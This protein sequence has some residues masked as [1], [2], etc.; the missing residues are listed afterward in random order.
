[1]ARVHTADGRAQDYTPKQIIDALN[2]NQWFDYAPGE[3][4]KINMVKPGGEVVSV[5]FTPE[6]MRETLTK[7]WRLEEPQE[8]YQGWMQQEY[9]SGTGELSAALLGFARGAT[10]GLSD[11]IAKE[12][13]SPEELNAWSTANPTISVGSEITGAIAPILLSGGAGAAKTGGQFLPKMSGSLAKKAMGYMPTAK[14]AK[15]TAKL[16]NYLM[17]GAFKGLATGKRAPT[18]VLGQALAR[19]TAYG[20]EGAVYGT[21]FGL[22]EAILQGDPILSEKTLAHMGWGSL[23][24]FGAGAVPGTI[25][26]LVRGEKRVIPGTER[27]A[28]PFNAADVEGSSIARMLESQVGKKQAKT[29]ISEAGSWDE[30]ARHMDEFTEMMGIGE[31]LGEQLPRIRHAGPGATEGRLIFSVPSKNAHIPTS[32]PHK[33]IYDSLPTEALKQRYLDLQRLHELIEID[34]QLLK[35]AGTKENLAKFYEGAK[36]ARG[37]EDGIARARELDALAKKYLPNKGQHVPGPLA[38]EIPQVIDSPEVLSEWLARGPSRE[39]MILFLKRSENILEAVRVS[40]LDQAEKL[41]RAGRLENQISVIRRRLGLEERPLRTPRMRKK[42]IKPGWTELENDEFLLL[43]SLARKGKSYAAVFNKVDGRFIELAGK[44]PKYY[45]KWLKA[46][47]SRLETEGALASKFEGT[48][49]RLTPERVSAEELETLL[50]RI[51]ARSTNRA[52]RPAAEVAVTRGKFGNFETPEVLWNDLFLLEKAE[53]SEIF[54]QL[55]RADLKRTLMAQVMK[56]PNYAKGLDEIITK[57][58]GDVGVV[59][60]KPLYHGLKRPIAEI[61]AIGKKDKEAIRS[62]FLGSPGTKK[63]WQEFEEKIGRATEGKSPAEAQRLRERALTMRGT[64]AD[65]RKIAGQKVTIDGE[66]VIVGLGSADVRRIMKPKKVGLPEVAGLLSPRGL[67]GGLA[68][69]LVGGLPG[70]AFGVLASRLIEPATVIKALSVVDRIAASKIGKGINHFFKRTRVPLITAQPTRLSIKEESNLFEKYRKSL[71][72][73]DPETA[74]HA[75]VKK[76]Q[77]LDNVSPVMQAQIQEQAM[78]I[79]KYLLD[80]MPKMKAPTTQEMMEGKTPSEPINK[81]EV[82]QWNRYWTLANDPYKILDWLTD[83]TLTTKDVDFMKA[84]YMGLWMEMSEKLLEELGKTS[85]A[86]THKEML[87]LSR[88]TG[89]DLA[90]GLKHGQLLASPPEAPQDMGPMPPAPQKKKKGRGGKLKPERIKQANMSQGDAIQDRIIQ[91]K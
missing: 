43:M 28:M 31:F 67:K 13:W 34:Q 55:H 74:M 7:K 17:Q 24:G 42:R 50:R 86:P 83:K 15:E 32:G 47:K 6:N 21:G 45:K 16:E 8:E 84:N 81:A 11:V 9:G 29:I 85:K 26:T 57:H 79:R 88:F 5:D 53:L 61:A 25:A 23:I 77:T 36:K 46:N 19:G 51:T 69:G 30:L 72:R 60:D 10:F 82:V 1:M 49:Y 54:G 78:G 80:N 37:T 39:E 70:A 22:S 40:A 52:A 14:L 38:E 20:A 76:L 44:K 3:A 48:A 59:I 75:I 27:L 18:R 65:V 91:G 64:P 90:Y 62:L 41:H 58:F 66:E 68:G 71:E 87:L 33:Q 63:A 4:P 35:A 56:D 2:T 12:I 73:N 89:I